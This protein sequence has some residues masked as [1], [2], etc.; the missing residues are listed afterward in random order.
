MFA[1]DPG[2]F[3]FFRAMWNDGFRMIIQNAVGAGT[4]YDLEYKSTDYF[5]K[6]LI[7]YQ[8]T[9]HFAYL[10]G[11]TRWRVR[12]TAV[13]PAKSFETCSSATG[14]GQPRSVAPCARN[15]AASKGVRA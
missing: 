4:F 3:Y 14:R 1:L 13:S 9:P 5:D 8:P 10:A 2:R 7:R 15:S 6:R 12:R 11:T